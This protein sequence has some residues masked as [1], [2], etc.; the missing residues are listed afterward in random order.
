MYYSRSAKGYTM[1]Y[2]LV[3]LAL[4]SWPPLPPFPKGWIMG[5]CP[6]FSFFILEVEVWVVD[7]RYSFLIIALDPTHPSPSL[8]FLDT[9]CP[10]QHIF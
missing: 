8:T 5:V 4:N 6:S 2:Y 10:V 9:L 7:L 1:R 3:K